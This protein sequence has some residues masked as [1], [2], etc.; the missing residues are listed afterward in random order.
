MTNREEFVRGF[1]EHLLGYA[2]GRKLELC[3]RPA[4][5]AILASAAEDDYRFRTIIKGIVK[6]Y[7]FRNTRTQ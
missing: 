7:P 3:D 6:S 1:I 4:V 2:L 5:D